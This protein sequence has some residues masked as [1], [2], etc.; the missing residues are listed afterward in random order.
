MVYFHNSNQSS[1]DHF[2]NNS[3][4]GN[5]TAGYSK[6]L[7]TTSV[8]GKDTLTKYCFTTE[9]KRFGLD[10]PSPN[11]DKDIYTSCLRYLQVPIH[12]IEEGKEIRYTKPQQQLILSEIGKRQKI[13]G[14][15]G[16]GKTLVLARRAVNA[17]K[18]TGERVL[19]L[20]YNITLKNYIHDRIN[21]VRETFNW[22]NFYI[23]NYH[24]FFK[25]MANYYNVPIEGLNDWNNASFFEAVKKDITPFS[26][27]FI[28]EIQDYKPE[29]IELITKYFIN[30]NTEFV[31]FGDSKQNIYERELDI[32]KE[33]KVNTI[34]GVWN[35]SLN[36]SHRFTDTIG[37][38]ALRFQREIFKQ[39]YTVDDIQT[40]STLDFTTRVIEYH[41]FES[42]NI[43]KIFEVIYEALKRNNIHSSDAGI[44][45]NRVEILRELDY[46]IRAKKGEKT[47]T[48]FESKEEFDRFGEKNSRIED[49]RRVKKFH[50]WMKTGTVKICTTHS[51]KGWEINTLFLLIDNSE[52]ATEPNNAELVY[53]GITRARSNLIILNLNNLHYDKFFQMVIDKRF[54]H[55]GNLNVPLD[56]LPF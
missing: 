52:N 8:L 50:F 47:C 25:A 31:V 6:L 30:S 42:V 56:G 22:D 24:Q 41:M 10:S 3:F 16:C 7:E 29:W 19:I 9:L 4:D 34:G 1:L 44:L 45:S 43:K 46:M 26:A 36:T 53:T 38:I 27:V 39:R 35:K 2:L 17:H 28:D 49:I 11:F 13:K 48:N 12:K 18:R 23:T 40:L 21:D 54:N 37:A 55:G 14:V 20:T 5:I 15:A 51:F 32:E 33:P